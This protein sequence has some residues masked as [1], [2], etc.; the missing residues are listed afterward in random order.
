MPDDSLDPESE[1]NSDQCPADQPE[2]IKELM[3]EFQA[4]GDSTSDAYRAALQEST[5]EIAG[6]LV[7]SGH[8]ESAEFLREVMALQ[9]RARQSHH[10]LSSADFERLLALLQSPADPIV[11]ARVQANL[12]MAIRS[13]TLS[14]ANR[15]AVKDATLAT[16]RHPQWLTRAYG[17][18]LARELDD[19]YLAPHVLPLR[20]D[21]QPEVREQ[22]QSL[23]EQWGYAEEARR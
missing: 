6:M 23:L 8:P 7:S 4:L 2:L 18:A 1:P 19:A 5:D 10:C 9:D 17:C 12:I 20:Y 3:E 22:A 21:P 13:G 11:L 15:E 14:E 16:L